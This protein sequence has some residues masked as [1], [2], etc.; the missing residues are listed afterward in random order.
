MFSNYNNIQKAAFISGIVVFIV[1]NLLIL[2][3]VLRG[4]GNINISRDLNISVMTSLNDQVNSNT[5]QLGQDITSQNGY[6]QADSENALILGYSETKFKFSNI[7]LLQI[8]EGILLISAKNDLNLETNAGT[9]KLF[10]NGVYVY[11]SY[12]EALTVLYGRA[13]F[14]NN[15][16]SQN[17]TIQID[18]MGSSI[19]DFKR[20]DITNLE[21]FR[22]LSVSIAVFKK[23]IPA[24]SDVVPP[25]II[26]LTP[27]TNYF[28]AENTVKINGK[29]ESDSIVKIN[30]VE[31]QIDS[32]GNFT[33][34]ISLS[35]G[36]NEIVIQVEDIYGNKSEQ[37]LSYSRN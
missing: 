36:L 12:E 33:S 16:I 27:T 15:S 29:T 11:N 5:Y 30:N 21:S 23:N 34:T 28:T 9:V 1:A 7:D 22:S 8:N 10:N 17:S 14:N 31:S 32:L 20:S 35:K 2:L 6:I 18:S 4:Q 37:I 25:K 19:V 26:S 3:I 13:Q 24:L